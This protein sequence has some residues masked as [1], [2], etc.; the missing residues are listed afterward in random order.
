ML[1]THADVRAI[2]VARFHTL[3]EGPIW[4]IGAGLGGVAIE[5]ARAFPESEVVAS[6]RSQAQLGYLRTNRA[7][8]EAYNLRVVAG[9]AP[10]CLSGEDRPAGVF[11]GGSGGRL[12]PLLD[13][14]CKRLLPGGVLV[15]NFVGLENLSRALERLRSE[16]WTTAL[17]Q[18]QIS[19]SRPLAGLTVLAPQH[20]VWVVHA[21]RPQ[22]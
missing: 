7:R 12:D 5:L 17:T 9:E 11:L 4:D 14:L 22:G 18:L 6:E 2:V 16:G 20:P 10:E 19:Q 15:A 13:L 8:F 3:P 21:F 1:L